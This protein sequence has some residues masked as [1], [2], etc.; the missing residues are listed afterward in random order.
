MEDNMTSIERIEAAINLKEADRVPS[1]PL[2]CYILPYRGGISI[3]DMFF[4]PQK[5]IEATIKG[6]QIV[7]EGDMIDPNITTFDHLSMWP[8]SGW[9]QFNAHWEFSDDFPPKGN[10]PSFFEKTIIEDYDDVM[11]RGFATLLFNKKIGKRSLQMPLEDILY[12]NFDYL[13]VYA[14]AWAKYVRQYQVPLL[15]GGRCCHPLDLLQYHR[16]YSTLAADIMNNPE[17]VKEVLWWMTDYEAVLGMKEAMIM[18]ASE[19]VPGADKVFMINGGPPGL[20]P[21]MW[22]EFYYPMAKR[23]ID[24]VV[25]RGFRVHLHW[26]NDL[27]LML[28]TMKD[29]TKGLPKGKMILDLEKT[30]MKKAKEI[31]GDRLCLYGNVSTTL[32]IFGTP[33]DVEKQCRQL[34]ED[35]AGGGGYILATECEVPWDGKPENVRAIIE[36]AKKYGRYK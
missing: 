31:L 5:L 8:K 3:K 11:E 21:D 4:N 1:D 7:G 33:K 23:A 13:K 16:G 12:Y 18:G 2:N 25:K 35:C 36:T 14:D 22:A 34:I 19:G 24:M 28:D 26:D 15:M 27:T 10:I 32:L 30:N 9:S 20:S 29:L 17:K 6:R